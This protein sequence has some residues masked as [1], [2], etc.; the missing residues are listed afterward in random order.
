MAANDGK[1]FILFQTWPPVV[2]A[3][4]AYHP[5]KGFDTIFVIT[6]VE[7]TKFY[8]K[9]TAIFQEDAEPKEAQ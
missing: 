8:V 1:P 5:G 6:A 9:R 2:G 4:V 7:G 3:Q